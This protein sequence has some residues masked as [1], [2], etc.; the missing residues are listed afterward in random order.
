MPRGYSITTVRYSTH[1]TEEEWLRILYAMTV[2]CSVRELTEITE[3]E[4]HTA[5]VVR[6]KV[7]SVISSLQENTKLQ[8]QTRLYHFSV[9]SSK[10]GQK[11][12]KSDV[13]GTFHALIVEDTDGN[14]IG[15]AAYP[16]T[17]SVTYG[18]G[19][20]CTVTVSEDVMKWLKEH[21]AS[22]TVVVN[23]D[24]DTSISWNSFIS[25]FRGIATKYLN[26]Y[27]QWFCY[28]RNAEVI[29]KNEE[30]IVEELWKTV[31]DYERKVSN[32]SF[33]KRE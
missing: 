16:G 28:L 1:L 5:E 23:N 14:C 26:E 8:G 12:L 11:R 30:E 6:F 9:K 24:T 4:R 31:N 19:N 22:E 18:Y 10:K 21:N 15:M 3:T 20:Q 2:P 17:V 33:R 25:K 29:G 7:L 27:I 32:R 13:N